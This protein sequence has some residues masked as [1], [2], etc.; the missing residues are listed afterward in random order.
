MQS[1]SHHTSD[2]AD[3]DRDRPFLTRPVLAFL[4]FLAALCLFFGI[5]S[6][7]TL[8]SH[9]TFTAVSARQMMST[10]NYMVPYQ[11]GIPRLEKPPAGYWVVVASAWVT[12]EL[13]ELTCRLPAVVSAVL[14]CGLMGYWA[15]RW[16]GQ[17]A[18]LYA[19]FAQATFIYVAIFARKSEPDLFLTLIDT[20]CLFL[21]VQQP[22]G[23]SWQ[24]G[25][26]RWLAIFALL[27]VS[28]MTK[29]HFGPALILSTTVAYWLIQKR[30]R[31]LI[32]LVNPIG[33]LLCL[34]PLAWWVG[35]VALQLPEAWEV[36]RYELL[37]RATGDFSAE[38]VWYFLP[39]LLWMTLP[40]T[41]L[42]FLE[43][44]T[45][46]KLAWHVRE[47]KERFLWMW[48]LIPLAIMTVQLDKHSQYL[49]MFLPLYSLIV[50]RRLARSLTGRH[51]LSLSWSKRQAI[52]LSV[53][54]I[55]GG[56]ALAAIIGTL[57]PQLAVPAA[58]AG[59]FVATSCVVGVWLFRRNRQSAGALSIAVT[60]TG[61]IVFAFGW[62]IPEQD[63]WRAQKTFSRRVSQLAGEQPIIGYDLK[64]S[65]L[66]YLGESLRNYRE[67]FQVRDRLRLDRSLLVVGY[68]DRAAELEAFGTLTS[69]ESV[70]PEE[71]R[72]AA[73]DPIL[74]CWRL[75]LREIPRVTAQTAEREQL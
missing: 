67:R 25:F 32:H 50:G 71:R 68:E 14:L 69:V 8:S 75:E 17:E 55:A 15:C 74:K 65:P 16:Y 4:V 1:D 29:F 30:Y 43:L 73:D 61:I 35:Y 72:L 60:Y 47:P 58:V 23:Q 70:T 2:L 7:K 13:N 11:A 40:W 34:G 37:G 33:W 51:W 56:I 66:F 48:F 39:H 46:W 19:A 59:A 31:D 64:Y 28:C 44:R 3:S 41:P 49:L 6:Y 63:H 27:G 20:L 36:W 54:S 5:S 45:S 22:A 12:G 57:L 38:P 18:G 42:W 26:W 21:I 24:R 9:E 10:G 53:L 62:M 52:R